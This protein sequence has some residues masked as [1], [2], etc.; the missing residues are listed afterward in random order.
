MRRSKMAAKRAQVQPPRQF[1]SVQQR[2]VRLQ[3]V[4]GDVLCIGGFGQPPAYVGVL[5]VGGIAYDLHSQ[6]EQER[7]MDLWQQILSGCTFPIQ[8]LWRSLPLRLDPYLQHFACAT[9]T[10]EAAPGVWDT[11]ASA[12]VQHVRA[13]AARR[14]LVERRIYV[15]TRYTAE[16]QAHRGLKGVLWPGPPRQET[17]AAL[18]E[19]R[20]GLEVRLAQLTRHL[21]LLQLSARRL[22]GQ[23]ELGAF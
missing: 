22:S 15:L 13:L 6:R 14:T 4:S 8:L 17:A 1:G 20:A 12:H 3:G 10:P 11:L 19:A 7:L 16:E 5:E 23:A 21:E 2:F 18:E 9:C